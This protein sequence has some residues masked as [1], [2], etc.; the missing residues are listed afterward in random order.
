MSQFKNMGY[1]TCFMRG[2]L[3]ICCSIIL[4]RMSTT[5][6]MAESGPL[7]TFDY[8]WKVQEAKRYEEIDVCYSH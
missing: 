5:I 1:V 8:S 2:I 4:Y 6:V 3:Y 7:R